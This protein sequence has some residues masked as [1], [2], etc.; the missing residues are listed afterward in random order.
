[1]STRQ[2]SASYRRRSL[3]RPE[4]LCI[5][6]DVLREWWS[7]LLLSISAALVVF[8]AV[9][10]LYTPQY[11]ATS[12]FVVSSKDV[13]SDIS[14]S[15]SAT[16]EMADRFSQILNS[17]ILRQKVAEDLELTD[18]QVQTS[19]SVILSDVVLDVIQPPQIPTSPSGSSKA[20]RYA[21]LS[22]VV[23]AVVVA[24]IL[25]LL[26][27][28]RD[29]VKSEQDFSEKVD[30]HLVGIIWH[31]RKRKALRSKGR[32]NPSMIITNQFLSFRY[33]EANK[34]MASHVRNRMD[35]QNAKVLM[36]SGVTENEGKSTVAANLALALAQEK[37]RVLLMDC[38][39]RK[40]A[41][42]KVFELEPGSF[43]NFADVLTGAISAEKVLTQ[44]P[45]TWLY[46]IF[47][48]TE[49][50]NLLNSG[51]NEI[52]NKILESVREFFDYII[53]DTAPVGLVADT[54]EIASLVDASLLV[55]RH[56]YTWARDINDVVDLLDR[57]SGR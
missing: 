30:A 41:Q 39:F 2:N 53:I 48:V 17:S 12:V 20:V 9:N 13:N 28:S 54:E 3:T 38:D 4:L 11:T 56:D 55:V 27:L 32:K 52:L 6:R 10:L 40:P 51:R 42:Y 7:V 57:V 47:N 21:E 46:G 49:N 14:S 29:T 44:V 22:F 23:T 8:V 31:E 26:S 33:V 24:G 1:M 37:K 15:L 5:A 50:R 43:S 18:Y 19:A 34:L 45:G 25:A 35:K 36:V 16:Y